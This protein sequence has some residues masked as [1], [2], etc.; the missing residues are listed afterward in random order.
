MRAAPRAPHLTRARTARVGRHR[1]SVSRGARV[2]RASLDEPSTNIW[3]TKPAWCQPPSVVAAGIFAA[4][5][6]IGLFHW[7]GWF[8]DAAT[9]VVSAGVAAW[10]WVFLFVVPR[11]YAA[12]VELE[13]ERRRAARERQTDRERESRGAMERK[14]HRDRDVL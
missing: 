5:A 1:A 11:E 3:D 8:A 7:H 10:W 14:T 12:A 4:S 13:L 9:L 2:P 6:P